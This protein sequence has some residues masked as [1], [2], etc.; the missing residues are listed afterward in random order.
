M[1]LSRLF[2]AGAIGIALV[3]TAVAGGLF[4]GLPAAT[5]TLTGTESIP[6]D[7]GLG[8]GLTPQTE[9]ITPAQIAAY[10]SG[11]TPRIKYTV[12]PVGS[13]A[14]SS[15]GNATTYVNGTIYWAQ[16]N[17]PESFTVT[18]IGCL[19]AG[20]VATDKVIYAL[21]STT[22]AL[23]GNTALAGTTTAGANAFQ[24]ISLTATYAAIRG[25]YF[26]A[27]QANGTTDNLRT[28]AASTFVDV[29]TTSATG[30]FGTLTA[31]T[32]PTTFTSNVGPICYVM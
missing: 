12:V 7:T 29:L 8:Q 32:V 25:R 31:L 22:G 20:T 14:Y 3:G 4:Q 26:V 16:L 17:I 24:E 5:G 21:Y 30:T 28:V 13:V 27:V 9:L 18:K 11:L 19:N 2:M 1:K 15:F 23:L 10:N 6:A